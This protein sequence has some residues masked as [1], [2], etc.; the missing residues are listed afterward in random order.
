M[1]HFIITNRSIIS[2]N[3]REYI[4]PNGK[5][6]A[7]ENLRFGSFD[8][9]EYLSKKDSAAAITLYPD[10]PAPV[11][12]DPVTVNAPSP[13]TKAD[14][15]VPEEALF[16]SARLFTELYKI[17]VSKQGG[18][19]LFF[20]HGFCNDLD[21]ALE[22]ICQMEEKYIRE[23]SPIKHIVCFTWPAM[24]KMLRYRDDA[25]DAELSGLTLARCY[26]ML[27]DYFRQLFIS[28]KDN[29]A[30]DP[31]GN[32]IHLL[33][34]SMGNRVLESMMLELTRQKGNNITALFREVI[35]AASDVDWQ[36]FEEPRVFY[37]LTNICQ[38]V[39]VYFNTCDKALFVSETTKNAYNRLGKYGF[40][41][42]NK[43]PS[44]IYSVD[45]SAVE[46][47]KGFDNRFVEHAYFKGSPAVVKDITEVLNGRNAENF[48][49]ALRVAIPGNAVQYRIKI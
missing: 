29:P 25:K 46:D 23:G 34:H 41:A 13:Y 31:C 32:N 24:G 10:A 4:N 19:L 7:G 42:L 2:K 48:I 6:A 44:H 37:N 43:L 12:S 21:G 36:V 22:S 15:I 40:R 8:S 16:G 1:K 35:L 14:I 11:K 5:E 3:G 38:R 45:C 30:L 27:I 28:D 39:T 20:I 9:A 49:P 17:M 47:E 18:D 33:A 26:L